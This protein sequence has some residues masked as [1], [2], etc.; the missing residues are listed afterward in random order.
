MTITNPTAPART[1]TASD[2]SWREADAGLWVATVRGSFA[3]SVD[4][5]D[6]Q[7][8]AHDPLGRYR[9]A[10]PSLEQAQRLLAAF[11]AHPSMSRHFGG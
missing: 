7:F 3:G 10:F 4:R 1:I 5:V 8:Q 6:G 9:G 11:A 2:F